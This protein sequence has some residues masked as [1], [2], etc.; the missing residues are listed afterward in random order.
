MPTEKTIK[1][2]EVKKKIFTDAHLKDSIDLIE[3]AGKPDERMKLDMEIKRLRKRDLESK[4]KWRESRGKRVMI[5]TKKE[6]F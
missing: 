3:L 2:Y 6:P 5:P 1:E 4:V